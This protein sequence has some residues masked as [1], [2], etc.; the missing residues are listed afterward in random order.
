[1]KTTSCVALSAVLAACLAAPCS[2]APKTES[3]QEQIDALAARVASLE[4]RVTAN[5]D[6]IAWLQGQ[7]TDLAALVQQNLT[8][9]KTVKNE[10]S[11]LQQ[12]NADLKAQMSSNLGDINTLKDQVA[13]NKE[14]VALLKNAVA[15][16]DLASISTSLQAQIIHNSALIAELQEQVAVVNQELAMKQIRVNGFC[17]DGS[18]IQQIMGDGSAVC[19]SVASLGGQLQTAMSWSMTE[20]IPVSSIKKVTATCPEGY[21]VTGVGFY[22]TTLCP[23][24]KLVSVA[25]D[26][27]SSDVGVLQVQNTGSATSCQVLNYTMCASVA[28]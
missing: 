23:F 2:A 14:L 16:G 17:P 3:L 7:N 27:A 22:I 20:Y 26:F 9:V 8:D 5:Q 1:M 15:D 28:P 21:K 13:A 4:E 18:A 11:S 19:Q 24:V 12:D 25:P 6:A 10:I